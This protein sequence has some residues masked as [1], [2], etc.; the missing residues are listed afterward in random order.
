LPTENRE[1]RLGAG[2]VVALRFATESALGNTHRLAV[3]ARRR[4]W[5]W[6][7]GSSVIDVGAGILGADVVHGA[8][9]TSTAVRSN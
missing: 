5:R 3:T 7:R 6:W 8:G 2:A 4:W 1:P 9:R